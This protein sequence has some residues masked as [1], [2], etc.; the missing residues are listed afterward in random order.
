MYLAEVSRNPVS[1]AN[2]I[3]VRK[4]TKSLKTLRA[5]IAYLLKT[6]LQIKVVGCRENL[7]ILYGKNVIVIDDAS[8]IGYLSCKMLKL[9]ETI[10]ASTGKSLEGDVDIV[11]LDVTNFHGKLKGTPKIGM[12]E[13]SKNFINIERLF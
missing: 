13:G 2:G 10:M 12:D 3:I 11:R 1:F 5:F 8:F 4:D 9:D 7:R 6:Y